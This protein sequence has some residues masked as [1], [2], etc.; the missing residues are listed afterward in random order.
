[1]QA[2]PIIIEL[3]KDGNTCIHER[4]SSVMEAKLLN[5]AAEYVKMLRRNTGRRLERENPMSSSER[6]APQNKN[7]RLHFGG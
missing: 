7:C 6:R 1:M 4:Y 3:D 2:R 5:R